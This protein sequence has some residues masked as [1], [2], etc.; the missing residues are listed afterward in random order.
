MQ[1]EIAGLPNVA[2]SES[3]FF[4]LNKEFRFGLMRKN[5]FETFQLAAHNS[6]S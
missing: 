1:F 3:F 6:D 4:F 5:W 2:L